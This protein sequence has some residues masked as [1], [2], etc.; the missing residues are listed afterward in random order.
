MVQLTGN[1]NVP[2]DHRNGPGIFRWNHIAAMVSA[3]NTQHSIVDLLLQITGNGTVPDSN[4]DVAG[5]FRYR[6]MVE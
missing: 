5:S 1:G 4:N 6:Y 3:V 2:D